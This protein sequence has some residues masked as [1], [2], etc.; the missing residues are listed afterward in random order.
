MKYLLELQYGQIYFTPA[1]FQEVFAAYA[2]F[3]EKSSAASED[4]AYLQE[5][6][7]MNWDELY[8]ELG[9]ML[10]TYQYLELEGDD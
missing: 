1:D 5:L 2:T 7:R 8:D 3:L 9:P 6:A 4:A 10:P